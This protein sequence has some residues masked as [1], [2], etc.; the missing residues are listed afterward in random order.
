MCKHDKKPKSKNN[1]KCKFEIGRNKDKES[2]P[3]CLVE[4]QI[5][6]NVFKRVYVWCYKCNY[7][8]LLN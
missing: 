1:R 2:C 8:K 5:Y 7:Y 3:I 6:K 4:L